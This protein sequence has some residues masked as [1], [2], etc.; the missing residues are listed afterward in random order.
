VR[1]LI[2]IRTPKRKYGGTNI[3]FSVDDVSKFLTT[4]R[5]QRRWRGKRSYALMRY[6]W[7]SKGLQVR[8]CGKSKEKYM[9]E[10]EMAKGFE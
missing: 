1:K 7:N 2:G 4:S 6:C 9:H 3:F 8:F 10:A 5:R